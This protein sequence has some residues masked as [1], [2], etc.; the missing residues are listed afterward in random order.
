MAGA[1]DLAGL[2]QEHVAIAIEPDRF[3]VLHVARSRSLVPVRAPGT[4]EE[5]RLPGR[6]VL[7]KAGSSIQ[8]IIKTRHSRRPGRLPE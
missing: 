8:A 4:R 3:D 5:V 1:T 6:D 7:L 2:D